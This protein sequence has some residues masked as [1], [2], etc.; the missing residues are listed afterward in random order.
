MFQMVLSIT[1]NAPED[2]SIDFVVADTKAWACRQL[3]HLTIE[4]ERVLGTSQIRP[5]PT[6]VRI[7]K[8][9]FVWLIGIHASDS[10]DL[11]DLV[12]TK[13][14]TVQQDWMSRFPLGSAS[15]NLPTIELKSTYNMEEY[16]MILDVEIASF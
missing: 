3:L 9:S 2:H 7:S 5:R 8:S 13:Q 14:S 4:L 10:P 15:E 12:N 6:P 1:V 11:T 16:L